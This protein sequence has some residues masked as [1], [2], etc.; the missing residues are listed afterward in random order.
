MG[1]VR[2]QQTRS[3]KEKELNILITGSEGV[4]GRRLVRYFSNEDRLTYLMNREHGLFTCDRLPADRP[5]HTIADITHPETL[6]RAF[7]AS[8]P[9]LVFHLAASVGRLASEAWASV[10]LRTNVEGTQ[11]V[12]DLCLEYGAR[13]LYVSTSEVYGDAFF[14]PGPVTEVMR[15]QVHQG[16]Y[17][18][19]KLHG[20]GLVRLSHI[21]HGLDAVI[22]RPFMC[23]SEDEALSP[24]RSAIARFMRS[25]KR[26]EPITVHEGAIRSW[27]YV[28]DMVEGLARLGLS[29]CQG[30]YNVGRHEPMTLEETAKLLVEE[31]AHTAGI[32]VVEMPD[33]IY[34]VKHASF[35]KIKRDLGWEAG[36]DMKDGLRRVRAY[37]L[38]LY[39]RFEVR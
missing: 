34:P 3:K 29:E 5:R 38:P 23:Y 14:D 37:H 11:N 28:E 10:A 32:N 1:M 35:D 30:V 18:L 21:R 16:I 17:G 19:S 7:E 8:R 2:R 22:A 15:T 13:L 25:I 27:C 39:E 31:T 36:I 26:G 9:E 33:G 6:R 12:V 4:I 20:E 24:Y